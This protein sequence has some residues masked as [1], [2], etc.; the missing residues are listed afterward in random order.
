MVNIKWYLKEQ[1]NNFI[2]I[3]YLLSLILIAYGLNSLFADSKNLGYLNNYYLNNISQ[4]YKVI[5]F[6][7]LTFCF[8]AFY[9]I[10][11]IV[12]WFDWKKRIQIVSILAASIIVM[13]AFIHIILLRPVIFI[14]GFILSAYV[15]YVSRTEKGGYVKYQV[16][17]VT[18]AILAI[19]A[20][21]LSL[22]NY[23]SGKSSTETSL[24]YFFLTIAFTVI[25]YKFARYEKSDCKLFIVGP[26][27][28]GKTVLTCALYEQA[29]IQNR[30]I[31]Q[32]SGGLA[33]PLSKLLEGRWPPATVQTRPY[34]FRY[35]HGK[36][37]TREVNLDIDYSGEL[38]E[39]EI[40][41]II[42]Y[43]K[44]KSADTYI[45]P[46]DDIEKI[47]DGLYNASKLIFIIDPERIGLGDLYGNYIKD[48]Y[49]PILRELHHKP[50]YLFVTKAEKLCKL[51]DKNYENFR[52]YVI[53]ELDLR[54]PLFTKIKADAKSVIPVSI[55]VNDDKPVIRNNIGFDK[56][57][58]VVG[59]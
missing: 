21:W 45:Q 51:S 58:E 52:T 16:S 26:R 57:L 54:D 40:K 29:C 4:S 20:V 5:W 56:A 9:G 31:G 15:S 35:I 33:E 37:F 27:S 44:K 14:I 30:N 38:L 25:F 12:A 8:G 43:L 1:Y 48:Y 34:E 7:L 50:Y 22:L 32:L 11:I 2:I 46:G 53:H 6:S 36:L 17:T 19:T 3:L 59:K 23:I 13:A 10:A 41:T 39:Q 49:M 18:L 24:M 28:A 42:E 55:S 47:A